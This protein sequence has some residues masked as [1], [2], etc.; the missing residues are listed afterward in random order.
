[1]IDFLATHIATIT[2]NRFKKPFARLEIAGFNALVEFAFSYIDHGLTSI[3]AYL[4]KFRPSFYIL[5]NRLPSNAT[6]PSHFSHI[7]FMSREQRGNDFYIQ[8]SHISGKVVRIILL[9]IF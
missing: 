4:L 7:S 1:M 5:V 9:S 2:T 6:F 8:N 3:N